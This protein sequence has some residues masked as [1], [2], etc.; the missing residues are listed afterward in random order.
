MNLSKYSKL[1]FFGE[2]NQWYVDADN[3]H[4]L[5]NYL[6]HGFSPGSFHEA[7]FSNDAT[8]ALSRSHPANNLQNLIHLASYLRSS[9]L[10]GRAFGS[11]EVVGAWLRMSEEQRRAI[12]ID[13][14]MANSE[15]Q[16]ID[17]ALRDDHDPGDNVMFLNNH[18]DMLLF[19][20]STIT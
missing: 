9:Y 2:L 1:K 19:D 16:D 8:A 10:W 3:M 20:V 15:A 5:Y 17:L 7:L 6:V 18:S 14:G 12:L 11:Y 13:A 4:Q